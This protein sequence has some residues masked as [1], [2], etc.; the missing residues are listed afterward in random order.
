MS[1]DDFEYDNPEDDYFWVED[2]DDIAVRDQYTAALYEYML[3]T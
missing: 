3:M 2:G 1:D